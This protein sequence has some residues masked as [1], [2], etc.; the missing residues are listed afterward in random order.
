M[1]KA[2]LYVRISKNDPLNESIENQKEILRNYCITKNIFD[3]D[4]LLEN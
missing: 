4:I 3:Y 1:I 2:G